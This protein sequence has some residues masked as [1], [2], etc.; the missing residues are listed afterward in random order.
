[1]SV[2]PFPIMIGYDKREH[3]AYR[4]CRMSL[5]RRSSIPLHIVRLDAEAL[6]DAGLYT[7]R[8]FRR[9]DGQ[10]ID[11]GDGRPFS[12]DFTFTRF[13]TPVLAAYQGWALFCDC[14]FLFTGD[15]APLL[16][17]TDNKYAAMCVKHEHV[18]TE[19]EKMDGQ[20]QTRYFRKNWSSF[21]LWNAAHPS[22]RAITIDTV[23]KMAGSWL[24]AF[25]WLPDHL[26][27]EIP[28]TWN[29][30]SGVDKPL[31]GGKV[32]LGIHFTLGT[33]DMV[34]CERYPYADLWLEE[35]ASHRLPG[36][37]PLPAERLRALEA[38]EL[39]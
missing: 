19:T 16:D 38:R 8:W 12:T 23:N 6:T 30:L 28:P 4:V 9:G 1:M 21:V 27:G 13:L 26:I 15:I 18:P 37:G 14:D 5:L 34:G 33:P 35:K 7:R 3:D 25:K 24:H 17:L 29:W 31:V 36:A 2:A 11:V 32:P 39:T 20:E 22:N 10:R